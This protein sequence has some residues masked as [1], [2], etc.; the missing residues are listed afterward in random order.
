MWGCPSIDH[1]HPWTHFWE[2]SLENY[3]PFLGNLGKSWCFTEVKWLVAASGGSF[4]KLLDAWLCTS[5]NG[6]NRGR[7]GGSLKYVQVGHNHDPTLA[8]RII[9]AC[10]TSGFT[11]THPYSSYLKSRKASTIF[12]N[13][14]SPFMP[15]SLGVRPFCMRNK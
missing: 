14:N 2:E 8:H 3:C 7:V 15:R 9:H 5:K 11:Q 13:H 10:C 1:M 4:P 12:F 6:C